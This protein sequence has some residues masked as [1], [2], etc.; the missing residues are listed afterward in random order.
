MEWIV[1][2][3]RECSP[4]KPTETPHTKQANKLKSQGRTFRTTNPQDSVFLTKLLLSEDGLDCSDFRTGHLCLIRE[5][6]CNPCPIA[7]GFACGFA[8]LRH[9]VVFRGL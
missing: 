8:A 6:P 9:S 2:K 1:L 3:N 5:N 7:L 4:R